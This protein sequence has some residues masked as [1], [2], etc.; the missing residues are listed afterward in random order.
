MPFNKQQ[1]HP[2]SLLISRLASHCR[3]SYFKVKESFGYHKRDVIVYRIEN[4]R[5]SLQD[6][7]QQFQCA[8][9][10]FGSLTHF[11]GGDLENMYRQLKTILALSQNKAKSVN[12]RIKA[13][14]DVAGALF[15]EWQNE[16]DQYSSRSLRSHSRQKLKATRQHYNRLMKAMYRAE[17]KI[18]PV[19]SA[20]RDQVLFLKHNLNAQA[21][22]SLHNELRTVGID[23]AALV[24]AMERSISEANAFLRTLTDQKALPASL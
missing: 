8:L 11:E 2:F 15:E 3:G 23:I 19:L 6:A 24:T 21:I 17:A 20:F 9:D 22:S 4:A 14:E 5:D 18:H 10:Q 1:S 12:G 16:L 7:K 13:V